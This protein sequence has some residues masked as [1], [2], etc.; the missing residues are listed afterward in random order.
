MTMQVFQT[1]ERIVFGC[2]SIKTVGSEAAKFGTSAL[3]VT[4]KSSAAKTGMLDKVADSLKEAGITPVIFAEVEQDPSVNT[5]NK[6]VDYAREKGCDVIVALGG[7]SPLDAA[8]AISLL[9]TNKGTIQDYEGFQS[10]KPGMPVIAIP[11][12]AG[13]ASEVTRFTVITDTE[14]KIKMLIGGEGI[15]PKVALLDP[16]LTETMPAGV[17]AA[18]GMDALTHA[19]EAYISRRSIFMTD[20]HALKAIE[21]IGAN[22]IKAVTDPENIEAREGMLMGQLQAGFAFSNS[23]VALVHSMSR[24]LGANFSIPHG[25]ANAMLL[26]AVMEYNRLA[27]PEKLKNVAVA[28]GEN[29]DGMSVREAASAAVKSLY[30]LF[31]ETGLPDTLAEYGITEKDLSGLAEDALASG[32]TANNPRKPELEDVVAIYSSILG[33]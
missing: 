31:E 3:V 23:S 32:S 14:R 7:G 17:T 5:V 21:L 16:E 12:T 24:P 29:V 26:A 1:P 22:L 2:G 11:T 4:G 20:I 33:T 15:I 18:T 8:K 25:K 19:I 28:L 27:C 9:I 6:G 13:T 30:T 10:Q